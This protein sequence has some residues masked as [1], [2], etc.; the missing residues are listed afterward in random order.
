MKKLIQ[1]YPEDLDASAM[2]AESILDLDP[3]KWWTLDGKPIE[4]TN[5]AI[6]VLD[7]ILMRDP[8][9]IGANHYYIHAWEESPTP[10]R[11]LMSA[12]RLQYLLPESGH[13]V[14]MSCHIYLP[15]GNYEDAVKAS[16]KAIEQDKEY[17]KKV[18]MDAGTYPQH[19]LSHNL[20]VLTRTYML[21]ED[22]DNAI[23][24]AMEV[25]NFIKPY[26][27]TMPHMSS[28][29]QIPLEVY[30]Y[31]H[32]WTEI[33]AYPLQAKTA[34]AQAY[35]HYS[36]ATAYTEL[37]DMGSALKEKELMEKAQQQIAPH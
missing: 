16:I 19:Y 28:M 5:E 13:L 30:L 17:S 26:F 31:F 11:A 7:F 18:G 23:K 15:T 25:L 37:G 8:D 21:M 20:Y 2:Y 29:G 27:E 14:H 35:W 33:L 4:G 32:K 24:T 9:H 22:Y 12:Y 34:S 10:Q 36:R 1:K 6:D 3:W